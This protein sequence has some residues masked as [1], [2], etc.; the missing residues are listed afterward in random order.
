[1]INFLIKYNIWFDNSTFEDNKTLYSE[2]IVT[3]VGLYGTVEI[4]SLLNQIT[5]KNIFDINNNKRWKSAG[6]YDKARREIVD[7][8]TFSLGAKNGYRTYFYYLPEYVGKTVTV[9][10]EAKYKDSNQKPFYISNSGSN[11][12]ASNAVNGVNSKE[13]KPYYGKS[14]YCYYYSWN[15]RWE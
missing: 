13:Y 15:Y 11:N 1:M 4:D 14:I 2:D 6:S 10:F 8:S 5:S 12:V 7:E 9:S 3:S